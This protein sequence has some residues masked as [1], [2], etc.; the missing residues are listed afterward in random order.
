MKIK[1]V[2]AL[3]CMF[4]GVSSLVAKDGFA[5]KYD[6]GTIA[7]LKTGTDIRIDPA[8]TVRTLTKGMRT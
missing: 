6:G 7:N 8:G 2:A 4:L 3:L 1:F 5:V